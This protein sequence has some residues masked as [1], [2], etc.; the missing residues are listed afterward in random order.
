MLTVTVELWLASPE[1]PASGYAFL[2]SL[3]Q[4]HLMG[5]GLLFLLSKLCSV[6]SEELSP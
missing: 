6:P 1:R 5:C 3:C 2:S 4:V